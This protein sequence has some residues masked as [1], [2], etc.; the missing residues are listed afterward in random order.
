MKKLISLLVVLFTLTFSVIADNDK[1]IPINE[2]PKVAQQFVSKHFANHKVVVVKVE[3]EFLS[4]SYDVMFANGDKIEFDKK[5]NWTNIDC[6]HSQVPNAII[7][8][9]IASYINQHFP[10]T[11]ILQIE[12][13]DRKGY[14]VEL[15]NG[16]ELEF[17]KQFRLVD[18]D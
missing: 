7:P 16:R 17:D 15:N 5:G 9:K 8:K 10:N 12:K 18:L 4:K 11:K 13:N 6:E 14:D 3:S 1:I 2:M